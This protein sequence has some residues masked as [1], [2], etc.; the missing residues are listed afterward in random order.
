M[1]DLEHDLREL[2]DRQASSLDTP[3]L[4]PK[5]V[6]RRGRR[7]QVG[8]VV[9]G[10]LA[11]IV[12]LGVV[13]V[14]LG[15]A[16]HPAV[17]PGRDN[18]LPERTTSIGGVPI[19]APAG[20]TLVDDWPLSKLLPATS[21]ECSFTATGTA[22][23]ENGSPIESTPTDGSGGSGEQPG[24]SCTATPVDY[25]AGF[26]VLQ[27]ANFEIPLMKTVCGLADQGSP[28]SIPDDGVAVYVGV[29][30]AGA[31]PFAD[32]R[33]CP[34]ATPQVSIAHISG[35]SDSVLAATV[36]AGPSASDADLAI[37]TD[38]VGGLDGITVDSTPPAAAGPGYVMAAGQGGGVSWGLEAAITVFDHQDG[39][40][41]V[42]A[43][44]T[45]TT[46]SD[47]GS[48]TVDL[49]TD[50]QQ[51]ADDYIDLGDN[52][53]VQFG[54]A[55]ADV[56][57]VRIVDPA[58]GT[59]PTTMLGWPVSLSSLPGLTHAPTGWIWFA[60]T[61]ARGEV[62]ASSPSAPTAA[63]T[64]DPTVS[65]SSDQLNVR[66]RPGNGFVVYGNDLGHD[67]EI[68][69]N[70][71]RQLQLYL[72][73]SEEP[74]SGMYT[75]VIGSETQIDVPGG[76]FLISLRDPTVTSFGVTTDATPQQ[77]STTIPGR[78]VRIQDVNGDDGRLWVVPLPGSGTGT[79][80]ANSDLPNFVS[81]PSNPLHDGTVLS[82]GSDGVVSWA[83]S[84]RD[85]HC[86]VLNTLGVDPG[87]SGTSDCL[88]PWKDL[89]ND[90]LV[91]G[92]YGSTRA[93]AAVVLTHRP[94]T[95]VT[96]PDLNEGELQCDDYD[97]ESNFAGT[98]ICVF[99][100]EVGKT[101]TIDLSQSD[102]PLNQSIT[103]QAE[104]GRLNFI[105]NDRTTASP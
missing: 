81:W 30:A 1:N 65:A 4:P 23:T 89:S 38:Y 104:P 64:T 37:A 28:A 31:K 71:G 32:P 84:Y 85:D 55:D 61:P 24:N 77:P 80:Q 101:V 70:D 39:S 78:W 8:T 2:F 46:D 93:T 72:D 86:V 35:L 27:M 49:P 18:G 50:Q 48:R 88:P 99:P 16:R 66:M 63:P 52:G 96:S 6:L 92:V 43:V 103:V 75:Y 7:R 83:L 25:A 44:M 90:P 36:V 76:A 26:P 47:T 12:A 54:T 67:W 98:T 5:A 82:G 69:L 59:V 73:G 22:V 60:P 20:W 13:A 87:N 33:A 29:F 10:V 74:T 58:G 34:N 105:G 3:G 62:Q 79:V 41:T 19:T 21:Q 57:G 40:P 91:G 94:P 45:T 56:T 68:Q 14:A 42:G 97:F 15:Q 95:K 100:V 17:I 9:T 51:I 102:G 53:V 11:C